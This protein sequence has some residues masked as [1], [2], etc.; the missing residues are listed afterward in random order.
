MHVLLLGV[1]WLNRAIFGRTMAGG[2]F[3]AFQ[4]Q[5]YMQRTPLP[6]QVSGTVREIK[7]GMAFLKAD[8]LHQMNNGNRNPNE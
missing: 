8:K 6:T 1:L 7:A 4:L 2:A 5:H 3:L